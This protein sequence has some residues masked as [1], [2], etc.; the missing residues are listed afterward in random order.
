MANDNG[1]VVIG[2]DGDASGFEQELKKTERTAKSAAAA[3]G[4]E[5][6]KAGMSLS[7]GMRKA[8]VEIQRAQRTGTTVT[9]NGVETIISKNEQLI[10]QKN[11][12]GEVYDEIGDS[13][14]KAAVRVKAGLADIKAGIDM[15]V[16]AARAL[17]SVAGTGLSYNSEIE[18][19]QTSFEVM[20][21][22]AEKAAEVVNRLRTMGA[23]T[24]FETADLAGTTQL[25][26][27]YGFT[28]DDALEKMRMLG[29]IAQGNKEALS[30]IALGYAQMSSAQKVNL[31][32]I[33]QMIN[34]GFNPLQEISERTGE[35]MNSLYDRISKG[36]MSV[37][38]ITASMRHAT[39]EGGKFFGGM[40]KQSQTLNGQLS[41][42]KDNAQQL[43]GSLTEGLSNELRDELL[44]LT[45]NMIGALQEAFDARGVEGLLDAA[46][47]ML[48][49]LLNMMTGRMED[50]IAS[51]EKFAP[52]AVKSIMS[53]I[54]SAIRS[55]STVLPQITAALFD[56]AGLVVQELVVMLPE[57]L[58]TVLTGF[59]NLF[60]E[61]LKGVGKMITGFYTGI[62]QAI[63]KGQTKVMGMWIDDEKIAKYDF[64]LEVDVDASNAYS[65]IES[66]YESVRTALSTDL[67][68]DDQRNEILDMIGDD[69]DDI[70]A[71]LISFGLS[72][73][74]ASTIAGAVTTAN[75][76]IVEE[77][78]KLDVGVPPETIIQWFKEARGSR[79]ALR[80]AAQSAGLTDEDIAQI[81]AAYDGMLGKVTDGTPSIM[82]EIYDKL[83]DGK[84]DDKQTVETLKSQIEAY[85]SEL[86]ANA[87][88][89]YDAQISEL[90]TTAADYQ[91]KK[92]AL[93]EWYASTTS[94]IQTMDSGMR[95][96]VDTLA[97]APTS[98]VQARVDE[99]IAMEQQ[100]AGIE[101]KIDQ[102][103]GKAKTAAEEAFQVVR[104]GAKVDETTISTAI[105]LKYTEFKVDTQSAEDAYAA[106]IK[107]LNSQLAKGDI[108]TEEY[109]A[110][111]AEKLS[112]ME[113]KKAAVKAAYEQALQEIFGGI[114][115]SEGVTQAIESAVG[116][117]D[118]MSALEAALVEL[119]DE[120]G[121]FENK[122]GPE[123]TEI[124]AEHLQVDPDVLNAMPVDTV[125]GYI[126]SWAIDLF[127]EAEAAI[128]ESSS[129]KLAGAYDAALEAGRFDGT[130]F[131]TQNQAEQLA[132]ILGASVTLAG[133]LAKP[134]A[135]AAGA[136]LV[137]SAA[138]GGDGSRDAGEGKGG[139]YG[140]GYVHGIGAWATRA[141]KA[142]YALAKSAA[143]GTADGQDS[144]SPSKIAKALGGD[145][146]EG[147]SIGLQESMAKA[148]NV[149]KRMTGQIVTAADL[150]QSMRVNMP[151]LQQEIALA[152]E[153][154]PVNLYV[155]GRELGRVMASDTNQAQ[156]AFNRKIAL[157]V[158]K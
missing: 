143:Q 111:S 127:E 65:N 33:K 122:F 60:N 68:T 24:P 148:A 145:F 135:E 156:N 154:N 72:D 45:N 132:A 26:M 117:I 11:E 6:A 18:K 92:T 104:A 14:K 78:N 90:D 103:S 101:D 142:A 69:Y 133:E 43:L 138:K 54:P 85:I 96:L 17:G 57:L 119:R 83:S 36:K 150:T 137:E 21:G 38:E 27:Q 102:L 56:V 88:A 94:E 136:G 118:L 13:S 146:G 67:L 80:T 115:E 49:D 158:G 91:E 95:T 84:P 76:T 98:V 53:G 152:N 153:Q 47:G 151:T 141:Y 128:A 129:E 42:L 139:D 25:L 108:T 110:L 9:I 107:E 59:Y 75:E 5:Y 121:M 2:I 64:T 106:A 22:S 28:A 149:A 34:G 112:E 52:K 23:E 87:K 126:E 155:N 120:S 116:K 73:T 15:A 35:S 131:D 113:T 123:F 3:L 66:A 46:T 97:G 77:L 30:S 81:T 100:L 124:L 130:S 7:D 50:S 8:W 109:D 62:E 147:Y 140:S 31:Q 82:Q 19:L 20:T 114:A 48:P 134:E 4:H 157:G 29:D 70:H 16:S 41:T 32:D 105:Q 12:L 58:P 89:A 63:H 144:N 55:G 37:D 51:L 125:R 10:H 39:S 44:P 61:G 74:D 86:L 1:H 99:L 40:E 79:I 93:D 71:K